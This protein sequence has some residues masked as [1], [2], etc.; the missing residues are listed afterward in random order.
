MTKL[1]AQTLYQNNTTKGN[2]TDFEHF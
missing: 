2:L 1:K